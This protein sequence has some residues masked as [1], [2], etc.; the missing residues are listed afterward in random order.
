MLAGLAGSADSLNLSARKAK[1]LNVK[2][3]LRQIDGVLAQSPPQNTQEERVVSFVRGNS[4]PKVFNV[5]NRTI[6]QNGPEWN[7][8][9]LCHPLVDR[10]AGLS[11]TPISRAVFT[12]GQLRPWNLRNSASS[13]VVQLFAFH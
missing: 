9:P 1:A 5:T 11:Y 12:S 7:V 6:Y 4:D 2:N 8:P 3:T 10:H 13:A